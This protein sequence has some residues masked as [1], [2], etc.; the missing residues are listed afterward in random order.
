MFETTAAEGTKAG[1]VFRP[2]IAPQRL[3]REVI[4][5]DQQ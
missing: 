2:F 3:E 5:L 4:T 1:A